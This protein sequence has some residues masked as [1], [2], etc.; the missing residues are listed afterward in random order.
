MCGIGVSLGTQI[1]LNIAVNLGLSPTKGLPLPFISYGNNN[2]MVCC[3][4]IGIALK[5]ASEIEKIR[6]R[7]YKNDG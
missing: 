1:F 4:S 5:V 7:V 2:L 3:I 6:K